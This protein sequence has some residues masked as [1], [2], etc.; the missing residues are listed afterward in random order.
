MRIQRFLGELCIFKN[1]AS[2]SQNEHRAAEHIYQVMRS[3]GLVANIEEFRSMSR[4]TWELVTILLFF[5]AEAVVYF[6]NPLVAAILGVIGIILFWGHFSTRF[7]PLSPVLSFAKSHNVIGKIP[8]PDAPFKIILTA[9]YDTARSGPMWNP[10]QVSSFRFTFLLGL[11]MLFVL[12]LISVLRIFD[13]QSLALEIIDILI[14]VYVVIQMAMLIY[15]GYKGELV[16]GASDNASGVAVML[17][18]AARIKEKSY[19]E[20][21]FWFVATGSEE[22]GALGMRAFLKKYA[23]DL[24]KDNSYFINFDNFGSGILH[25]YTVEGMINRYRFSKDLISASEETAKQKKF[26]SVTPDKYTLAYTDAI[27]PASRGYHAILFLATDEKG[28]IPNWHWKTDVLENIDF[29]VPELTSDFA[30]EMIQVHYRNLMGKL[31]KL[32]KEKEKFKSDLQ[33]LEDFE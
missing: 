2:C 27:V 3:I 7:K 11:G 17:D 18:L 10:K 22:V 16:Q 32:K 9:H 26:S 8:N 15:A 4:M 13:I 25:Y 19:P 21:E 24:P 33:N 14:G 23:I 1:R 6:F 5:L 12:L 29:S 30:F 31:E 20:A 28:L